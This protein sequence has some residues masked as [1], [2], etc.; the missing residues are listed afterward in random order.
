MSALLLP[1]LNSTYW[2]LNSEYDAVAM[3]SRVSGILSLCIWLF[4]QLPQVLENYLNESVDGISPSFL[5]CWISGDLT[6]LVGC[7]LTG[8][9]PFQTLLAGY[10]CFIDLI[11]TIQFWYYKRVFPRHRVHH[12]MLQS[13]NCI[14]PTLSRGSNS[15]AQIARRNRFELNNKSLLVRSDSGRSRKIKTRKKFISK[16]L[17]SSVLSGSFG[18]ASAAPINEAR[19][20]SQEDHSGFHQ[21]IA[22]LKVISNVNCKESG[23][24]CGWLSSALYLSSRGPQI[25]ENFKSKST[26]GISPYLFLF[27]LLGNLFYTMSIVSDL[28]LLANF[29]MYMDDRQF[30]EV[31]HSQLPFIIGSAGTLAFDAILLYQFWLY[32]GDN[33]ASK[34]YD[35]D[36]R[37]HFSLK[38][39]SS[40]HF[41]KPDWYTNTFNEVDYQDDHGAHYG[42]TSEAIEALHGSPRHQNLDS[43]LISSNAYISLP[44]PHYISSSSLSGNAAGKSKK[45]ILGT[46]GLISRSASQSSH[47]SVSHS[48]YGSAM[49]PSL[50]GTYS[51]ISKRMMADS[52]LPLSPNDFL[53]DDFGHRSGGTSFQ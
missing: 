20:A 10:Y 7:L 39:P 3:V 38:S 27:A 53:H 49:I 32:G 48:D 14:R 8:A 46:F 29:D 35:A 19:G 33:A 22:L 36:S 45:I 6:N 9:L 12:N 40:T 47:V 50:V 17:S 31:L 23:K 15:A 37:T 13:P 30:D 51:S 11:L 21:I 5:G 2:P 44:P 4:A 18:K 25:W 26:K 42:S 52:K 16:I 1:S 41:T 43:S 24:F 34:S 28:Y